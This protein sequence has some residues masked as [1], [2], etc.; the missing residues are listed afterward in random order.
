MTAPTFPR[1][2]ADGHVARLSELAAAAAFG[3][4]VGFV[5]V[6]V[7]DGLFALIGLGRFGHLSGWLAAILPVFLF[8]EDVRAWRGVPGRVGVAALAA[9]L[10]LVLGSG[11]AGLAGIALPPLGSGAVGA[12]VGVEVYAVLWYVGI[13]W[14]ADRR[15]RQ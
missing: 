2:D 11:A 7:V 9:V 3:T 1:R 15:V 12:L 13:R 10:A 14:L 5:G 8:V 4:V 6:V